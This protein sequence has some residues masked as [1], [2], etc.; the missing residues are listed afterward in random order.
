M[1]PTQ[2]TK[3]QSCLSI[4]SRIDTATWSRNSSSTR[5]TIQTSKMSEENSKRTLSGEIKKWSKPWGEVEEVTLI[6]EVLEREEVLF[7]GLKG[8][9]AK[10]IHQQCT[11]GWQQVADVLKAYVS[12]ETAAKR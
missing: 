7:G 1:R 8:C 3:A 2:S 12:L 6:K 9:D 5:R 10:S 4:T 11:E